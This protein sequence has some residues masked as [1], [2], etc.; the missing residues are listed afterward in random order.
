MMGVVRQ[1]DGDVEEYVRFTDEIKR[2][3]VIPLLMQQWDAMVT[4]KG[5][6]SWR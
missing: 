3:G 6:A 5:W 2:G 1:H 4:E